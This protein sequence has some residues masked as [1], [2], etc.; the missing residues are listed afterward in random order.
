[1][2][3]ELPRDYNIDNQKIVYIW[4]RDKRGRAVMIKK[5]KYEKGKADYN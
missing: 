3:K 2:K 4:K 1:M 5:R